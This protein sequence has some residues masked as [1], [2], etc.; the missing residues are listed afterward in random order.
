[1]TQKFTRNIWLRYQT[2][3]HVCRTSMTVGT[4]VENSKT[5]VTDTKLKQNKMWLHKKMLK[6]FRSKEIS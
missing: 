6:T 1:M 4:L 5:P 2:R 3:M